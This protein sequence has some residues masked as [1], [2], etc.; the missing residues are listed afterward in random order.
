MELPKTEDSS[1]WAGASVRAAFFD[2]RD[3]VREGAG[4]AASEAGT[5]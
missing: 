3:S 4:P 2:L 1:D 5:S